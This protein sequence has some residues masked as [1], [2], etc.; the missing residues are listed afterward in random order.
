MRVVVCTVV[1]HPADLT[2]LLQAH[3][4]YDLA[5]IAEKAHLLFDTRG[6]I[7]GDSVHPL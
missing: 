5:D 7:S 6:K 1:H 2:I 3:T 4:E